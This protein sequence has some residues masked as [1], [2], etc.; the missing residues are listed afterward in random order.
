VYSIGDPISNLAGMLG[1]KD[2]TWTFKAVP[3]PP[4][5]KLDLSVTGLMLEAAKAI[6]HAMR[7][8]ETDVD[9]VP[10]ITETLQPTRRIGQQLRLVG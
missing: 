1:S 10:S 2:L 8:E 4:S 3:N 6:D 5:G 7:D 9:D